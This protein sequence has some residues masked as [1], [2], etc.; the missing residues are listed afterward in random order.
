M[1]FFQAL[2]E[3][4]EN[5]AQAIQQ[6]D[7][8]NEQM[9]RSQQAGRIAAIEEQKQQIV[10]NEAKRKEEQLDKEVGIDHILDYYKRNPSK[11]WDYTVETFGDKFIKKN[12]RTVMKV[13]DV[14]DMAMTIG[15]SAL[16]QNKML[17]LGIQDKVNASREIDKQLVLLQEKKAEGGDFNEEK[18]KELQAKRNLIDDEIYRAN[19]F[20]VMSQGEKGQTAVMQDETKN[21]VA[22]VKNEQ[23][24]FNMD[25]KERRLQET[26]AHNQA[27]E[28]MRQGDMQR[29]MQMLGIQYQKL[30]LE[31]QKVAQSAQNS[32][33]N[34]LNES[35]KAAESNL[36]TTMQAVKEKVGTNANAMADITK[37]MGQSSMD[38]SI[39]IVAA[40]SYIPKQYKDVILAEASMLR[41]AREQAM[42]KY[43]INISL[44]PP[45]ND[46]KSWLQMI[47]PMIVNKEDATAL[48]ALQRGGADEV[49]AQKILTNAKRMIAEQSQ[50]KEVPPP[51]PVSVLKNPPTSETPLFDS[52]FQK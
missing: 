34:R 28:T 14:D 41:G 3:S 7:A 36:K 5:P 45:L 19:K 22:A 17:D 4:K 10:L 20:R 8:N 50:K 2:G 46:V 40:S 25:I 30:G 48:F 27:L 9:A 44:Y 1:G 33:F 37:A 26:I 6:I 35:F 15:K 23:V 12:G 42:K 31:A 29:A 39:G 51:A 32:D 49:T 21:Q 16:I 43:G 47:G 18:Y 11:Q 38:Q 24:A 52:Y 13:R